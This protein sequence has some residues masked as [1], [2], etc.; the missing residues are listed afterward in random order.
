MDARNEHSVT[1]VYDTL[2]NEA[3][4][5]LKRGDLVKARINTNTG[6]AV[7]GLVSI[8]TPMDVIVKILYQPILFQLSSGKINNVKSWINDIK[9]ARESGGLNEDIIRASMESLSV[10]SDL[11]K[12]LHSTFQGLTPLKLKEKMSSSDFDSQLRALDIFMKGY[13]IGEDMRAASNFFNLIR[14]NDVFIE[15]IL[16]LDDNLE[17]SIGKPYNLPDG[18]LGFRAVDDFSFPI[19]NMF[20]SAPHIREAY[21]SHQG[22]VG[23][24]E[25]HIKIH[26]IPL[27][28]FSNQVYTKLSILKDDDNAQQKRAEIRRSLSWYLLSGQAAPKI[29][30]IDP[31]IVTK[32]DYSTTISPARVFSNRVTNNI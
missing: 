18:E 10:T 16:Q 27:K 28:D 6:S 3:I 14:Q 24:I 7:I 13:K 20:E 4:D 2:T 31:E 22:L 8:G 12:G 30:S 26:S 15:D 17:S 25:K 19:P 5:N 32:G 21:K 11:D 1:A 29:A 9:K 23:L